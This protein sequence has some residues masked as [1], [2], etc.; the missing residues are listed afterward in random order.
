MNNSATKRMPMKQPHP[1]KV[2]HLIFSLEPGGLENGVVNISN[3][4][5]RVEFKTDIICLDRIGSFSGR[6]LPDVDVACLSRERGFSFSTVARLARQLRKI[7]PDVIHTHNLGPLIYAVLARGLSLRVAPILHGEH[8]DLQEDEKQPRRI[9]QRRVLYRFCRRIHGVSAGLKDHLIGM[10]FPSDKISAIVNGV[11]SDRFYPAVDRSQ[12]KK[13]VGLESGAQV[14]GMVGRFIARKRHLLM[15]DAFVEIANDNAD[16]VLLLL[17]D[18]GE[19]KEEILSAIQSH[20]FRDRIL[21]VGH[22]DD[23]APWYRAMDLLVMPSSSEGLSN[24]LLEAMASGVPSIAHPVCG[25]AEVIDDG[26]NG[27]LREIETPEELSAVVSGLLADPDRLSN[28]ARQARETAEDKF[29]INRMVASYA[30][31]YREVAGHI[32]RIK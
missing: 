19:A 18:S 9:R 22:Q 20:P 4:L 2:A 15:L 1:I 14:I 23:P 3:R 31:L 8:C 6:L 12:A 11:D 28:L 24:A 17:G 16:S 27:I 26:V 21:W 7:R 30:S 25:A 13:A 32:D 29:S 10:G 5:D